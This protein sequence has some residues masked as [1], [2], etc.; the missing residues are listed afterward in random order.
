MMEESGERR[1]T[2]ISLFGLY[3]MLRQTAFWGSIS[4]QIEKWNQL[5]SIKT[6]GQQLG[7]LEHIGKQLKKCLSKNETS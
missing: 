4:H 1:E 2:Q 3:R 7:N 5:E 6:V